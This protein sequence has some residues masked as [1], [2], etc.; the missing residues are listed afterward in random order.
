[1]P[2]QLKIKE[3][4]IMFFEQLFSII[5]SLLIGVMLTLCTLGYLV[6]SGDLVIETTEKRKARKERK[7][8]RRAE[9]REL[10]MSLRRKAIYEEELE[11]RKEEEESDNEKK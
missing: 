11:K 9:K 3:E 2:S 8:K 5:I 10:M 1:M 7:A 6:I 4:F